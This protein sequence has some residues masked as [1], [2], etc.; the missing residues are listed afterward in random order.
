MHALISTYDHSVDAK[1]RI[2]IPA[3]LKADLLGESVEEA[4]N[5]EQKK[6]SVVFHLGTGGCIEVYTQETVDEI[7][8]KIGDVKKS[9]TEKYKLV[10]QYMSTFETVDSDPQGR[11]VI[12]PLYKKYAKIEK[13]IKICGGGNHIKIWSLAGYK[14]YFGTEE[15]DVAALENIEAALGI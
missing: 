10:N 1:N 14:A 12:P 8:A 6:F 2:R 3:K 7:Y 11:L 15:L 13:E 5:Q 4:E 9:D